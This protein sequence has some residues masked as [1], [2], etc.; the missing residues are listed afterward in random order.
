LHIWQHI[1]G[2]LHALQSLVHKH[3]P[4]S[5]LIGTVGLWRWTMWLFKRIPAMFY[6]PITND[7]DCTATVVV[8][9]FNE[10]P[11]LFRHAIESWIANHPDRIIVV[12]D[13]AD[14]SGVCQA[15]AREYAQVETLFGPV[16]GK[17]AALAA[18]VDACSTDLVVLAD[19]DVVWAPDV[20]RKLKM[21]F[22]NPKIGGVGSRAF[23]MPSNGAKPTRWERLADAFLDLRYSAEV[24]ATTLLSCAVGC[25]SGRTSAYRTKL[26]QGLKEPFLNET[27]LGK[28]CISGD[29]KCYTYLVLKSGYHTWC[30]LNAH[31]YSTFRPDFTGFVQQR[32]RW[33]RN[34]F[35]SELRALGQGW[36][37]RYPY[38]ALVTLDKNIGLVTQLNGPVI[39]ILAAIHGNPWLMLALVVWW[40]FTRAVKISAH[41]FRRPRDWLLLPLFIGTSFFLSLMKFYAFFTMNQQGWI[42]RSGATVDY[43]M[44]FTGDPNLAATSLLGGEPE[45]GYARPGVFQLTAVIKKNLAILAVVVTA[46]LAVVFVQDRV[47]TKLRAHLHKLGQATKQTSAHLKKGPLLMQ[48]VR[49]APARPSQNG[50]AAMNPADPTFDSPCTGHD[51]E[52]ALQFRGQIA[53]NYAALLRKIKLGHG[54]KALVENLLLEKQITEINIARNLLAGLHDSMESDS[55]DALKVSIAM[56]TTNINRQLQKI[57]GSDLY[58]QYEQYDATQD[59]RLQ[60]NAFAAQLKHTNTP[61][62]DMQIDQLIELLDRPGPDSGSPLA[63]S[64][65]TQ[66]AAILNPGQLPALKSFMA[67]L[68]ARRTILAI[69]RAALANGTLPPP[70]PTAEGLLLMLSQQKGGSTAKSSSSL[71]DQP[72]ATQLYFPQLLRDPAYHNA[73]SVLEKQ[74]IEGKFGRLFAALNLSPSDQGQLEDFLTEKKM[75]RDDA[76]SAIL[77]S[78]NRASPI[79]IDPHTLEAEIAARS[80][81][82]IKAI[83]WD[84]YKTLG[85]QVAHSVSAYGGIAQFYNLADEMETRLSDTSTPL[86]PDQ[87]DQVVG[88]LIQALGAK[89]YTGFS[90]VPD[91]VIT[92]AATVL[93]P[94]QI[95][96]LKQIQQ[97]RVAESQA[98]KSDESVVRQP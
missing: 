22:A 77:V 34:S 98:L 11:V 69:N 4:A 27:F 55:L 58:R 84:I 7:Y 86:Q 96:V 94:P 67:A 35:R 91:I 29:D 90:P 8:A 9:V 10:N 83:G 89:V 44:P 38:L 52:T 53:E 97:E 16:P 21:P 60:I 25:L 13:L 76:E 5:L 51:Q 3:W 37:W 15:V 31:V 74:Q 14:S 80:S 41:L 56:G 72:S 46:G 78:S 18:G 48:A 39:F 26:L 61:L 79:A 33:T 6:R 73:V 32:I 45:T 20:L 2:E 82:P 64:F 71:L 50:F 47:N 49:P 66:A 36:L 19:S 95:D 1:S 24:P 87:A 65:E 70:T 57:L 12:I 54:K 23:M 68:Q 43:E 88:L 59:S 28:Q 63:N 42:T 93:S 75:A 62:S 30:Q 40:H 17:R 81:D 85:P 92:Q